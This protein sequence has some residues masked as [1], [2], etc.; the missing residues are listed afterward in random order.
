MTHRD[1][2]YFRQGEEGLFASAMSDDDDEDEEEEEVWIYTV[3]KGD[4]LS[5]IAESE[6]G[7]ASRLRE[8]YD[9]NKET[10]GSNPDRIQ[11]G[12][13]LEL[14]D[15]EEDE[16]DEEEDDEEEVWV[17]TVEKGDTLSSIA[18]N[19]LGDADRW[20]EIYELNRDVIGS[21]PNLIKP[22]MELEL[23]NDDEDEEEDEE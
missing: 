11:P 19:E 12:M 7:D 21:N 16:D 4:T 18:E 8:I 6:L 17:Y 23:P 1:P 2:R 15:D 3:E 13:E 14:P 10:I 9:L 5:S 22:G 20:E